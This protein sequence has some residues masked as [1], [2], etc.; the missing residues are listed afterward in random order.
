MWYIFCL[1]FLWVVAFDCRRATFSARELS[2]SVK[3]TACHNLIV[4]LF[5]SYLKGIE[6]EIA[7]EK[8]EII[9]ANNKLKRLHSEKAEQCRILMCGGPLFHVNAFR[10]LN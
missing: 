3:H 7:K 6:K 5:K 10:I 8:R 1:L 4:F 9:K 2:F